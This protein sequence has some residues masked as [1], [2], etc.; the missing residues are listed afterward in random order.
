MDK[1]SGAGWRMKP[2]YDGA[3]QQR[4][5][6]A[7]VQWPSTMMAVSILVFIALFWTIGQRTLITFTELFRW[8]ADRSLDGGASWHL[9]MEFLATRT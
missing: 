5:V 7:D 9:Q 6:D 2:P 1:S 3:R 8:L 4:A